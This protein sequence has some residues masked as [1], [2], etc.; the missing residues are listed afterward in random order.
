MTERYSRTE[1]LI[2]SEG[3]NRLKRASV[4]VFGAGGVGSYVIEALA[5]SGIGRIDV[6]DNDTVSI[7]NLNRQ[8]I[9][10]DNTVGISKAELERQRILAINPE[11]D[12]RAI[13]LFFSKENSSQI[14][15]S[16]YDYVVDAIDTVTG[17]LEI[18]VRA[19]E[20]GAAVISCMGTGNKRDPSKFKVA[21]ISETR[22]CPLARVMRKELKHRGIEGV[23]AVFSE[24]EPMTPGEADI[25]DRKGTAGRPTPGSLPF[26][27]GS[28]GLVIAGQVFWDIVNDQLQA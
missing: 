4:A 22:V 1:M 26:V 6:I 21:D 23:K 28:A 27:P 9:A 16:E 13:N 14:D 11:A 7:S 2:G 20:A 10:L 3:M 24:E 8:L 15:F 5:R 18:I 19:K 25:H 12:A 17:K